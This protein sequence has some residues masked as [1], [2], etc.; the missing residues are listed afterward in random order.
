M[1]GAAY[2]LLGITIGA[3]FGFVLAAIMS[4]AAD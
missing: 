2:L 1:T 4:M 3:H